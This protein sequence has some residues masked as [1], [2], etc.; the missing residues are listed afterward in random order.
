MTEPCILIPSRTREDEEKE[1]CMSKEGSVEVDEHGSL[2]VL[3]VL[4]RREAVIARESRGK[5]WG[6]CYREW[7]SI[8][9][10]LEGGG[11]GRSQMTTCPCFSRTLMD[12]AWC[13]GII[14]LIVS[15]FTFNWSILEDIL[16]G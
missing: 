13:S 10:R 11:L 3:C 15:L 9:V 7:E 14:I 5:A 4:D 12:C 16:P 8:S 1:E 2:V 6:R